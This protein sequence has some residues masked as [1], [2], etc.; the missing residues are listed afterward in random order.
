MCLS[1]GCEDDGRKEAYSDV[2]VSDTSNAEEFISEQEE[3]ESEEIEL[4]NE[5]DLDESILNV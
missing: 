5:A 1:F 2:S 3:N 4:K